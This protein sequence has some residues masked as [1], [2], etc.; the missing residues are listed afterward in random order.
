MIYTNLIHTEMD[1]EDTAGWITTQLVERQRAS[2][3]RIDI[4]ANRPEA[5]DHLL[6][7]KH[8]WFHR[9]RRHPGTTASVPVMVYRQEDGPGKPVPR[10]SAGTIPRRLG[11]TS[12]YAQ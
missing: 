1:C 2:L 11:S 8:I 5:S 9:E 10:A 4:R 3:I 7:R 12:R 6:L